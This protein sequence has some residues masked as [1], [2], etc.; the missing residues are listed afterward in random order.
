[1]FIYGCTGLSLVGTSRGSLRWL[2]LLWSMGLAAPWH[3]ESSWTRIKPMSPALA[4]GLLTTGSRGTSSDSLFKP[5]LPLQ[6]VILKCKSDLSVPAQKTSTAPV[7]SKIKCR[8][9][10]LKVKAI[11][12]LPQSGS[13]IFLGPLKILHS[14][15]NPYSNPLPPKPLL[16]LTL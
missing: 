5:P 10:S 12:S 3:V 9:L 11:H 13:D 16:Q 1:M 15:L 4:G 2:L 6:R 7:A 14:A 8:F